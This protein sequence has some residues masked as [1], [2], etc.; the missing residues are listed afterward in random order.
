MYFCLKITHLITTQPSP[1]TQP[2][3]PEPLTE[4]HFWEIVALLD[5]SKTGV[6]EAIAEPLMNALAD[7]PEEAIR[8]FQDILS[9]KL[10]HL[11][12]AAHAL[13]WLGNDPSKHISV[14]YFLYDPS[15]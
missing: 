13:A 1:A 10:W 5:W 7:M 11:N 4:A 3:L 12:T 2:P 14:D 8:Q 9:E 6:E 15:I